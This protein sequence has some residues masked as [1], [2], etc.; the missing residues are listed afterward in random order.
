MSD[1][2][3]QSFDRSSA[4]MDA[5]NSSRRVCSDYHA[6][7]NPR[8]QTNSNAQQLCSACSAAT[9]VLP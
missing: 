8:R 1:G 6:T 9:V 3:D 4:T 5:R 7:Q 2:T